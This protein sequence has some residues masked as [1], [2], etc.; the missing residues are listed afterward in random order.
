MFGCVGLPAPSKE[1]S[2]P[3]LKD[4]CYKDEPS[5]PRSFDGAKKF[6]NSDFLVTFLNFRNQFCDGQ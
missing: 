6:G 1:G 5:V 2:Y 3:T 4:F